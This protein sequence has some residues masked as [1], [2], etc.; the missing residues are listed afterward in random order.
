MARREFDNIWDKW[1]E[2]TFV[3]IIMT[4]AVKLKHVKTKKDKLHTVNELIDYSK[5]YLDK[6]ITG[7]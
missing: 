7:K 5:R 4:K 2:N 1:D 6:L 3:D